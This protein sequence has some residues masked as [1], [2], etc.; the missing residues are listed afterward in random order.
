ATQIAAAGLEL[1]ALVQG[2]HGLAEIGAAVD[3][4]A[5]LIQ[6]PVKTFRLRKLFPVAG[7]QAPVDGV[8]YPGFGFGKTVLVA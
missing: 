6:V 5:L 2:V 1:L 8:A 7:A 3:H 4:K